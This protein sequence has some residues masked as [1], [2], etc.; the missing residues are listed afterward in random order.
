ML[1]FRFS[2]EYVQLDLFDDFGNEDRGAVVQQYIKCISD[3]K[4]KPILD[5]QHLSK[6][7]GYTEQFLFSVSASPLHFYREYKIA[8]KNGGVRTLN[9][10]LPTLKAVQK[11]IA[12]EILNDVE[13]HKVAKAFRKNHTLRGNAVIHRRRPFM[14]KID[15]KDFFSNITEHAIYTMFFEIGYTRQVSRLLT[16]LCTL[17][18]GLPQGAPTS[19]M[20]S[21]L[22]MRE[23][24][25]T[26]FEHCVQNDIFYTR[27]ADDMA[28]SASDDRVKSLIPFIRSELKKYGLEIN[29]KKTSY[30]GPGARKY[31]TGIVVNERLNVLRIDRKNIRQEMYYI[32]KFGINGHLR[33]TNNSSPN[34]VDRLMGRL[35][36][37]F[38]VTKEPHFLED[39]R[40]LKE[41]KKV[42]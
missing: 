29:Q 40:Y 36:F 15:I 24:D 1:N 42:L 13:P 27:Y 33:K 11:F 34:Y 28:F 8:K 7:V 32:R 25:H 19:P 3:N 21:N 9:E 39:M 12:G 4:A 22:V 31:V 18:N 30:S 20:L 10:P 41:L 35:N 26:V 14:L 37:A 23:F 2:K 16:G 38:F 6:L 17:N 5:T